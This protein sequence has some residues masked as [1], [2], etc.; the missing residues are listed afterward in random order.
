MTTRVINDPSLLGWEFDSA[1]G[2]WT[3]SGGGS[4]GGGGGGGGNDSRIS[5]TQIVNWDVAYSWGDHDAVDYMRWSSFSETDPTVPNHVKAI[6]QTDIANWNSGTGG[7]GAAGPD[8]RISDT[9]ISSWDDSYSWGDHAAQNYLK[10]ETD[11]T[12]PQHVK[13]ITQVDINK[14]NAGT[15]DGSGGSGGDDPRITDEQIVQW[16]D[17]YSWGDHEL[18]DYA[19]ESWVT[20]K[21]YA[22]QSWVNGKSYATETWV[23]NKAYATQ[24]WVSQNYQV[25]GSY[26]TSSDLSGYATTSW[27]GSN[28]QPKG[29]YLVASDL[30]GYA[31]TVWVDSAYS[32]VGHNHSGVYADA[33]HTHSG[34]AASNHGHTGYL[35]AN[36]LIPYATTVWVDTAYMPRGLAV[37]NNTNSTIAGTLTATDFVASSDKNK[38]KNVVTAPLGLVEQLRGVEFE[39]KD[40]GEASSGVIAQEVE[41]V[42]PHLVH[43]DDKGDLAVSYMGLVGYL[44]EEVK[45][46]RRTI[47]E[48]Y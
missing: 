32:P 20:A 14:W 2:R 11:P 40:S 16:D 28:Y 23:T 35:T 36:D 22:T 3:W 24:T 8:P 4:S 47:E 44:I 29:S 46:L 43:K 5:D 39:W 41:K 19:T 42:L 13:D 26:L 10:S 15:G 34:Y 7:G 38:K 6:T 9:Q 48:M 25:K 33:N 18:M 21:G 31:T 45:D 1:T 37:P 27:V 12:V 30:N 17:A